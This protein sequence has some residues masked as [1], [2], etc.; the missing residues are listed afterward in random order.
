MSVTIQVENA[1]N[2]GNAAP[3]YNLIMQLGAILNA[4]ALIA[5]RLR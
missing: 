2:F 3:Y 4:R 5:R 1:I